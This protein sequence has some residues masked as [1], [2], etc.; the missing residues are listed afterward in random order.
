MFKSNEYAW[1]TSS[2][3]A[4][5]NQSVHDQ[6]GPHHATKVLHCIAPYKVMHAS[7]SERTQMSAHFLSINLHE[8]TSM[9]FI[10]LTPMNIAK[11]PSRERK[12]WHLTQ[13]A[14]TVLLFFSPDAHGRL[15]EAA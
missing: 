4:D 3:A 14:S 15:A 9:L 10:H 13:H 11:Q 2:S 5:A 7:I 6:A 12:P 8:I 1:L